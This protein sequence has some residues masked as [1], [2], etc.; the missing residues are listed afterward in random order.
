LARKANHIIGQLI[1][2]V[3]ATTKLEANRLKNSEFVKNV[4]TMMTGTAIAQFVPV[5]ISPV[6]T[7]IFAPDD[8]G[9][10]TIF[11]SY[12]MIVSTIITGK[13][14]MAIML[15]KSSDDAINLGGLATLLTAVLSSVF[16]IIVIL[17]KD[18]FTLLPG[19]E[20]ISKWVIILPVSAGLLAYGNI[21]NYWISRNKNFASIS[22]GKFIQTLTTSGFN[23]GIGLFAPFPLILVLGNLI[24]QC[25][26]TVYLTFIIIK[27]QGKFLRNLSFNSFRSVGRKYIKFPLFD[28]P[29]SLSYSISTQGMN[30]VFTKFFGETVLG[31]FSMVQR[32]LITPFSFISLSFTQVF[33]EKM[34][35]VYNNNR[36]EFNK[37]LRKA[38][39]RLIVYFI[40]PFFAFVFLSK[41]I[42]PFIF[43]KDWGIMYKYIFV[44]APMIFF[45]LTTSP[46]TYIFKILNKQEVALLL[47]I[48]RMMALISVVITGNRLSGDP[49]F[50]FALFSLASIFITALS[51]II[52]SRYLKSGLSAIFKLQLFSLIVLNIGLYYL[53]KFNL[54]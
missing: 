54:F 16:L 45:N 1:N 25:L 43:G 48:L 39:D 33:F 24:G 40:L 13:Y 28:I 53:L 2:R 8:F 21:L 46:Y 49:L 26:N 7:R 4:T 35:D 14:E 47:N 11:L 3:S 23:I 10:L 30:L 41:F 18:S 20:K 50:V 51:I 34:S 31:Y 42:V 52:C 29:N 5:L 32:I 17:F 15:P 36:T 38:Q 9:I 27:N 44:L 37:Y 22:R 19:V 12:S 6:L